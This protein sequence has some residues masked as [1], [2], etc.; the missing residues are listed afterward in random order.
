VLG[1]TA[2]KRLLADPGS[3]RFRYSGLR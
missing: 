2:A 3:V 1:P